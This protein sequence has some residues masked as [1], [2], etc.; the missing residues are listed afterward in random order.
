MI[1][2]VKCYA[3]IV[4]L[5]EVGLIVAIAVVRTHGRARAG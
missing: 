5:R 2:A 4:G 3:L 1:E